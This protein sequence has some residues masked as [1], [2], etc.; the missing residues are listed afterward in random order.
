MELQEI[1]FQL[2]G[3]YQ[4]NRCLSLKFH[5]MALI[6]LKMREIITCSNGLFLLWHCTNMF[7][8]IIKWSGISANFAYSWLA[9]TCFPRPY[10]RVSR[11][12]MLND[13][14]FGVSVMS[15]LK[16]RLT[17]QILAHTGEF[18]VRF[19]MTSQYTHLISRRNCLR[20][21]TSWAFLFYIKSIFLVKFPII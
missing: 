17:R 6:T 2:F 13:G 11:P 7:N 15:Q 20:R 10:L 16:R 21:T 8:N 12:Q 9:E 18:G 19:L 14:L 4:K 5:H 3:K 1:W